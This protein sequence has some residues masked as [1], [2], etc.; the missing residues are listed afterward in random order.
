ML[1]GLFASVAARAEVV[2]SPELQ[3]FPDTG[4]LQIANPDPAVAQVVITGGPF[5]TGQF[6]QP[7]ST[8]ILL[9]NSTN[10]SILFLHPQPT[11]PVSFGPILPAGLDEQGFQGRISSASSQGN[12]MSLVYVPEPSSIA[13]LA[14]V[15]LTLIKRKRDRG[16]A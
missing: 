6:N 14:I 4:E 13:M 1:L 12:P 7:P 9:V 2:L 10:I 15:G 3:Y 8:G 11:G 5:L 16:I